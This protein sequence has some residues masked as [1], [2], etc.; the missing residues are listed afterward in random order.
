MARGQHSSRHPCLFL[1]PR[2]QACQ[3]FI[4]LRSLEEH[5]CHSPPFRDHLLPFSLPQHTPYSPPFLHTPF[6]DP[7]SF[8]WFP[9][10][11]RL[12]FRAVSLV[13]GSYKIVEGL[14]SASN[15]PSFSSFSLAIW[16]NTAY[17]FLPDRGPSPPPC[18]PQERESG[19]TGLSNEASPP[20][21]DRTQA[22]GRASAC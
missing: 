20:E 11:P 16:V 14:C 2:I 12:P 19:G 8:S 21:S 3:S 22:V 17:P 6:A 18:M 7:Y 5:L 15:V 10:S 4:P 13:L 1:L 9:L